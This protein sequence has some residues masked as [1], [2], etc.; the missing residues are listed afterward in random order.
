MKQEYKPTM[1]DA[2]WESN[3]RI[4][5]AAL[6]LL[7]GKFMFIV[8][9]FILLIN[10]K[11]LAILTMSLYAGLIFTAILLSVIELFERGGRD[12]ETCSVPVSKKDASMV[13]K[14]KPTAK[15]APTSTE[16]T[17]SKLA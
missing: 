8:S 4:K 13:E 7:G 1:L 2:F 12:D 10:S 15:E 16:T 14:K 17:I 5:A 3:L 11:F 6:C 9:A